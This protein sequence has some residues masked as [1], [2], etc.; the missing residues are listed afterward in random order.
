MPIL[1]TTKVNSRSP[2]N[3]ITLLRQCCL[4]EEKYTHVIR[5]YIWKLHK[6]SL[7]LYST[8]YI[9]HRYVSDILICIFVVKYIK[10]TLIMFS[11]LIS[12][13]GPP[14]PLGSELVN[15]T[16]LFVKVTSPIST[17][18]P[19]L[20]YSDWDFLLQITTLIVSRFFRNCTCRC[21]I[22]QGIF[23]VLNKI[24]YVYIVF[25]QGNKIEESR[26]IYMAESR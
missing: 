20:V 6:I 26:G 14:P 22:E 13:S 19:F 18:S 8:S 15:A 10:K 24:S 25:A 4:W 16:I 12:L 21:M 23:I 7:R 3:S 9:I 11:T 1:V 2:L 5:T 17:L